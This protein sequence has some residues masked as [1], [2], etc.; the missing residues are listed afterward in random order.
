MRQVKLILRSSSGVHD[1]HNGITYTSRDLLLQ[2]KK[3]AKKMRELGDNLDKMQ[4]SIQFQKAQKKCSSR[5]RWHFAVIAGSCGYSFSPFQYDNSFSFLCGHSRK[6]T[7]QNTAKTATIL[8]DISPLP[9][10]LKI[11][12]KRAKVYA[13][14][15]SI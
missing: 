8:S 2:I 9:V 11:K 1:R 6:L 15:L 7:P 10:E 5:A 14:L 3:L 13:I 4:Y 12:D